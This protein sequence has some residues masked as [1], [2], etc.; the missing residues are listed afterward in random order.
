[1]YNGEEQ[2]SNIQ[3]INLTKYRPED[4]IESFDAIPEKVNGNYVFNFDYKLK[5]TAKDFDVKIYG[6]YD[7]SDNPSL[8][9]DSTGWV[10]FTS[11]KS[12]EFYDWTFNLA[13]LKF[14]CVVSDENGST[15]VEGF[16]IDESI[17]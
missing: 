14:S 11:T 16:V 4:Y 12:W 3:T 9:G 15:P 6:M 2:T 10:E 17:K 13:N 8:T 7:W 1:V 5:D